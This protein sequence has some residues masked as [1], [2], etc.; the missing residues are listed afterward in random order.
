MQ[1]FRAICAEIGEF[2]E[3]QKTTK[4]HQSYHDC[5]AHYDEFQRLLVDKDLSKLIVH[6]ESGIEKFKNSPASDVSDT[7]KYYHEKLVELKKQPLLNMINQQL[8]YNSQ[9]RAYYQFLKDKYE[10]EL[11]E[12]V[13]DAIET[14]DP[15]ILEKALHKGCHVVIENSFNNPTKAERFHQNALSFCL[16]Q[17]KFKCLEFLYKNLHKD[18]FYRLMNTGALVNCLNRDTEM[19]QKSNYI[20]DSDKHFTLFHYI[21]KNRL[22]YLCQ[23]IIR[24]P[25]FDINVQTAEGKTALYIACEQEEADWA[26]YLLDN[27]ADPNIGVN[28]EN[29]YI[30]PLYLAV[31]HDH[32][33]LVDALIKQGAKVDIAVLNRINQQWQSNSQNSAF[34]KFLKDKYE[35]ELLDGLFNDLECGDF[36]YLEDFFNKEYGII[37][38]NIYKDFYKSDRV[39]QNVVSFCLSQKKFKSL[40]FLYQKLKKDELYRLINTNAVVSCLS[41]DAASSE[42]PFY[43]LDLKQNYT[44]FHYIVEHRLS[45][46]FDA[47][48]QNP[49]FDINVQ[50]VEG[51]TALYIACERNDL[52]WAKLLLDNK[53][54]PNV[55]R[56]HGEYKTSPLYLAI[57]YK[58]E[59]L[60]EELINHGAQPDRTA[61]YLLHSKMQNNS[62]DYQNIYNIIKKSKKMAKEKIISES[63]RSTGFFKLTP[64][65][66]AH[67]FTQSDY[68]MN[69]IKSRVYTNNEAAKSIIHVKIR[70]CFHADNKNNIMI[71]LLTVIAMMSVGI[72]SNPDNHKKPKSIVTNESSVATYCLENHLK[73]SIGV[74]TN[75]NSVFVSNNDKYGTLF[76]EWKHFVDFEI[77]NAIK[78]F[79]PSAQ[80][81]FDD[82]KK[83][84]M[85][86]HKKM[87][88][89]DEILISIK[90]SFSAVFDVSLTPPSMTDTEIMARVPEVIGVLG[91]KAG[92]AWLEKYTPELLE[93]Y[94]TVYNPILQQ[95]IDHKK[96]V[97]SAP[98]ST[99]STNVVSNTNK[100]PT[101]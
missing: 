38:E 94:K 18:Q 11:L 12:E 87:P 67:N 81:R 59:K 23:A 93:F 22:T 34:Y 16:S 32:I 98:S 88:E 48:M 83:I 65:V 36:K 3:K 9:N 28:T 61:Y 45:Y 14:D 68:L 49:R 50:T 37:I 13:F 19:F 58:N 96:A 5:K 78:S 89:S 24:N 7:Q 75:K 90:S 43:I 60:V 101:V 54:N 31:S 47:I 73:P 42:K 17:K 99:A 76:H 27:K 30:T 35:A 85:E 8:H 20:L 62:S 74:Y 25:K 33:A 29:G 56:E 2:L 15:K 100:P 91:V 79:P 52:E 21:I 40:D 4:A 70:D 84:L 1:D 77:F 53:A 82:I 41:K 57:Y 86:N 10:A 64:F 55:I 92:T 95:Y 66:T 63:S 80:A 97:L 26:K 44:L 39:N 6:I 72:R 46:H 71:P 51:K 69:A